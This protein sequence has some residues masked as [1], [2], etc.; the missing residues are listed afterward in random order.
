MGLLKYEKDDL[1]KKFI[2]ID[3][4]KNDEIA[5]FRNVANH[6]EKMIENHQIENNKPIDTYSCVSTEKNIKSKYSPLISDENSSFE[7]FR[8]N[9]EMRLN[10]NTSENDLFKKYS[11]TYFY[12]NEI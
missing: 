2:P 5:Y 8:R 11:D 10:T 12:K 4:N 1:I 9:K 7:N 3:T 6:Y